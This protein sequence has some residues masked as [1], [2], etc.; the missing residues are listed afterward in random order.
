MNF[1]ITVYVSLL[2]ILHYKFFLTEG[3][4]KIIIKYWQWMRLNEPWG[5]L[6]VIWSSHICQ[7]QH[8]AQPVCL[9]DVIVTTDLSYLSSMLHSWNMQNLTNYL[10]I[11]F[12][13]WIRR[14]LELPWCG[15]PVTPES[16]SLQSKTWDLPKI[17]R[18]LKCLQPRLWT[19]Q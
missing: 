11:F 14:Q 10:N 13:C 17:F 18:K 19:P 3:A 6:W 2:F 4:N 1:Y 8:E 16:E 9:A 15:A 7:L 12:S 5:L